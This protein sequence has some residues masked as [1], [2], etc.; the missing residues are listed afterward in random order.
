MGSV[1]HPLRAAMEAGDHAAAWAT[2]APDVVAY[3]PVTGHPFV[4]SD[5]VG[6]LLGCLLDT[7][8]ELEYT[9]EIVG[10][11]ARVVAFR[12]R[13]LGRELRGL[14]RIEDDASGKVVRIEIGARP[15]DAV[16]ALAAG[17]APRFTLRRRGPVRAALLWLLLR[18]LPRVAATLDAIGSLLARAPARR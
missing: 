13:V 9:D 6:V 16:F 18:P 17:A 12:G 7:F 1:K 14:E 11:D 4:G 8:D 10:P 3:S 5:E 2:L 15:P